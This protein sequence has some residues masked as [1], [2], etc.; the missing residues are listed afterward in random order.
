MVLTKRSP[1]FVALEAVH[2]ALEPSD[3]TG[4]VQSGSM[5]KVSSRPGQPSSAN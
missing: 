1:D 2:A 5:K 4:T 3:E